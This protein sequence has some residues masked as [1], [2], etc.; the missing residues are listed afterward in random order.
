MYKSTLGFALNVYIY[1]KFAIDIRSYTIKNAVARS[2]IGVVLYTRSFYV[3]KVIEE[4][5]DLAIQRGLSANLAAFMIMI[6]AIWLVYTST[7]A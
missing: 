6:R 4:W 3:N 2:T 5:P 7:Y 1:P